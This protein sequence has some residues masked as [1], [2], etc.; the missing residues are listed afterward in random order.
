M[1]YRQYGPIDPRRARD[2]MEK[3]TTSGGDLVET[4]TECID[5]ISRIESVEDD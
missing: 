2:V 1:T 5:T 3:V 4:A